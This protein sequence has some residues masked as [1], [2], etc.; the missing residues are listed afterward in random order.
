MTPRALLRIPFLFAL[1]L[2]AL[3]CGGGPPDS[4]AATE[5]PAPEVSYEPAYPDDV[6]SEGLSEEDE[7]QQG[8]LHSHGDGVEH[9]HE[10]GDGDENAP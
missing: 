2:V 1:A 9:R 8:E 5:S 6:S 3:A 4:T 7:A 10:P